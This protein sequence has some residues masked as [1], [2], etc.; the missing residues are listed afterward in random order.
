MP[1]G[2]V[3]EQPNKLTHKDTDARW[4]K[5]G[6][7][8][9]YNYK[10]HIN[11]DNDTKPIAS[12]VCTDASV[13]GSQMF[14][15]ILRNQDTGGKQVWTDSAY[16]SEEQEQSPKDSKHTSQINECAYRSKPLNEN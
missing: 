8:N 10:N 9:H 15:A 5:K 2:Q 3:T 16:R 6:G 4:A 7:Q 12:H 14:E 13:H 1:W 11:I